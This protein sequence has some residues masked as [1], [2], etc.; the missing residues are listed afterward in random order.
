MIKKINIIKAQQRVIHKNQKMEREKERD[1]ERETG[2][3]TERY[4]ER[5]KKKDAQFKGQNFSKQGLELIWI[6]T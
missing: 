3:E 1:N 4:K 6:S 5:Y 2:G